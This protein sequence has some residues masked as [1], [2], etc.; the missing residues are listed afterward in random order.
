MWVV[1]A[2][3]LEGCNWTTEPWHQGSDSA[4]LL[5]TES[6][7]SACRALWLSEERALRTGSNWEEC[8]PGGP[9]TTWLHAQSQF[10]WSLFTTRR[11]GQ[12]AGGNTVHLYRGTRREAEDKSWV[13]GEGQGKRPSCEATK[14][15][16][17]GVAFYV[18]CW[19]A[20]LR[21]THHYRLNEANQQG[22]ELFLFFYILPFHFNYIF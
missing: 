9:E 14:E 6:F 3:F 13:G 1:R 11:Q 8:D 16:C 2:Y 12:G 19:G 22:R 21:A 20:L 10:S 17:V 7:P 5:G 18:D 15:A 4:P